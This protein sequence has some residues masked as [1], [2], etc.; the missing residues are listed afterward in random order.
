MGLQPWQSESTPADLLSGGIEEEL[1]QKF[2]RDQADQRHTFLRD[3]ELISRDGLL[4]M[5]AAE[6]IESR[7]KAG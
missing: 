6:E 1:V 2:D 7:I 3:R 5:E 4:L